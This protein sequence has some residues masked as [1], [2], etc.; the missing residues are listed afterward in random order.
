MTI[1]TRA[2]FV[3]AAAMAAGLLALTACATLEEGHGYVPDDEL[4]GE[5]NVGLDTKATTARILGRPGTTG[6]VDDRGWFYVR[7]EYERF[8]WRPPVETDREVVSVTFNEAGVVTNIERFGLEGG[9][10]VALSR[11]VTDANTEGVGFLRQ[12]FSNLGNVAASDFIR[13]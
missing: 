4:L 11:R 7:S 10:V 2:G 13:E 1:R 12:L 9:R 5:I 8:L 3:K 6:I